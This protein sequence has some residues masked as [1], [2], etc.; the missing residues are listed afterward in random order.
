MPF[1]V[2]A[3]SSLIAPG[4]ATRR[5]DPLPYLPPARLSMG[6]LSTGIAGMQLSRR[7]LTGTSC[8]STWSRSSA[9]T[10]RAMPQSCRWVQIRR[11]DSPVAVCVISA[12]TPHTRSTHADCHITDSLHNHHR[13]QHRF[14]ADSCSWALACRCCKPT[15]CSRA[16]TRASCPSTSPRSPSSTCR[17][18]TAT[19]HSSS[20]GW[21]TPG[22]SGAA[23]CVSF[24]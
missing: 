4:C 9:R 2:A 24:L 14:P 7:G 23:A 10:Y 18:R 21:Q 12:P 13:Q 15:W 3:S 5:D 8:G 1:T 20:T 6:R 16:A 19:Y 22:A 11:A 17:R